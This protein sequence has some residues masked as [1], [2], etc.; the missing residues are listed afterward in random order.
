MHEHRMLIDGQLS[1]AQDGKTFQ[2]INPA[3]EEVLGDV[4]D[5]SRADAERAVAAAR[6]AF[7]E[8]DWG[9]D[10]EG[11]KQSLLQ[12]QKALEADREEMRAELIAEAGSPV[13]LTYGPQ[14]DAPVNEAVKWPAEQISEFPWKRSLG[15]KDPF[16]WGMVASREG[17]KEPMGGVRG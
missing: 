6:R 16:G 14:L 5:G 4:T 15:D 7:D 10:H 8:T 12:L 3:T 11:R 9:W 17:G 2:N 13:L 1:A